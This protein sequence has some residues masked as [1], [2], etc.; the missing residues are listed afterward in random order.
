MISIINSVDES[1]ESHSQNIY[2]LNTVINN[3]SIF[4]FS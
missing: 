3:L 4:L 2:R 1:P